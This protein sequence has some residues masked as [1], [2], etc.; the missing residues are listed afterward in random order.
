MLVTHVILMDILTSHG[1]WLCVEKEVPQM[2]AL[3]ACL[4]RSRGSGRRVAPT[5]P[6]ERLR[7]H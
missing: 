6:V 1:G 4:T 2:P 5:T 7:L 3:D